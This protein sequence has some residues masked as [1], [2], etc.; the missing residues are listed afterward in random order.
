MSIFQNQ[1]RENEPW[2][3]AAPD[4]FKKH[5]KSATNRIM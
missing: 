4:L 1:A 2:L 3:L 5:V